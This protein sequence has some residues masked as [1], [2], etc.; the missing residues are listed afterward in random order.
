MTLTR[1]NR[2][3][4]VL[5]DKNLHTFL[6][7]SPHCES[8]L[9]L[10][11]FVLTLAL[12]GC[13]FTAHCPFFANV[14]SSKHRPHIRGCFYVVFHCGF[15]PHA[16]GFLGSRASGKLVTVKIFRELRFLYVYWK[17]GLFLVQRH[18][19]CPAFVCVTSIS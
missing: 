17:A 12:A 1:E 8:W 10:S 18:L 14:N 6:F 4:R 15:L 5:N 7:G 16:N 19:L 11:E 3:N 9:V 2:G 13:S